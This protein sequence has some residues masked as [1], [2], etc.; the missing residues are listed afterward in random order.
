MIKHLDYLSGQI[1]S[2]EI[3]LLN[4]EVKTAAQARRWNN[5]K[6]KVELMK[7]DIYQM[8]L[9]QATFV[10][11]GEAKEEPGIIRIEAPNNS[12][13]IG[14]CINSHNIPMSIVARTNDVIFVTPMVLLVE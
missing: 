3:L 2:L 6:N 1:D 11:S 12:H 9:T 5:L 13:R 7:D 4:Q 10:K 8:K 14:D